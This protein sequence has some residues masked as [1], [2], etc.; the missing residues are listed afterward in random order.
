MMR[1][2]LVGQSCATAGVVVSTAKA[3]AAI[4]ILVACDILDPP[5]HLFLVATANARHTARSSA[6]LC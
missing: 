6:P 3:N 4:A 5:D 2:G 1:I